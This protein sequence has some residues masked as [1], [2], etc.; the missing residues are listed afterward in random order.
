MYLLICK[1]GHLANYTF[2]LPTTVLVQY[3]KC[4]SF[5]ETRKSSIQ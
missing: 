3:N 1:K 5:V 2:T 4:M